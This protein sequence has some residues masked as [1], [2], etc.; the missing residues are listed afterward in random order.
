MTAIAERW[1]TGARLGL[2]V[3]LGLLVV[4]L[5]FALIVPLGSGP[6][7]SDHFIKVYGSAHLDFGDTTHVPPARG[8]SDMLRLNHSLGAVY[9]M[10]SD[11]VNPTWACNASLPEHP[12]NCNDLGANAYLHDA[13]T[14]N[15]GSF[16]PFLYVVIGLPSLIVHD[17]DTSLL[18]MR[19]V[20]VVWSSVLMT[21]A[22][23]IVSRRFG[24][25]VLLA[26][27]V[28][29][30]PMVLYTQG[31]LGTSGIETAAA[32]AALV[33]AL[34]VLWDE[35]SSSRSSRVLLL[36]ASASL[37]LCRP[38]SVFIG[39]VIAVLVLMTIGV[40][41]TLSRIRELPRA[42]SVPL[43]VV[44]VVA[45]GANLAWSVTSPEIYLGRNRGIM[46]TA[47]RYMLE[48]LPNLWRM[49]IGLFEWLD[50]ELPLMVLVAA[51]AAIIILL[52][53]VF[54][55]RDSPSAWR[56]G[57][58]I[59]ATLAFGFI[60]DYTVFDRVGGS[61]Q[62]RHLLPLF[63]LWTLVAALPNR[64]EATKPT[65]DA[66]GSRRLR[67][68]VLVA[69]GAVGLSVLYI[70]RRE[71]V[72]ILGPLNFFGRAAWHPQVG[73]VMPFALAVIGL[74]V[75]SVVPTLFG[76]LDRVGDPDVGA[77]VEPGVGVVSPSES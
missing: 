44:I 8:P 23:A 32:F 60:A 69:G 68:C 1:R 9:D 76:D 41:G 12:A 18:A 55:N 2:V 14:S 64:G 58:V 45:V 57:F 66:A 59:G 65:T 74:V 26:A 15:F 56:L 7:E 67:I 48:T 39:A 27:L 22:L 4:R 19:I 51:W 63:Q 42:S 46:H 71:A 17:P 37:L 5:A 75:T 10:G 35:R 3:G 40:R 52:V 54:P 47:G 38:L 31:T 28:G 30:T 62:G 33:A 6:D 16:Q 50:T 73:W 36:V 11:A 49:V 29:L 53:G 72:G 34:D 77:V 24:T 25:R 13:A 61:V 70:A 21:M 43:G 20:I